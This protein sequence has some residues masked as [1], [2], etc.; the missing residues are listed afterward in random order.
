MAEHRKITSVQGL[1]KA[2]QHKKVPLSLNELL[3]KY[4]KKVW[5]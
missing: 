3:D 4:S 2:E 5:S 1:A